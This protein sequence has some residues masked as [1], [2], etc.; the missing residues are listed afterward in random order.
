[1]HL[2]YRFR[3]TNKIVSFVRPLY[4]IINCLINFCS[5]YLIH[6]PLRISI[7]N[8]LVENFELCAANIFFYIDESVKRNN[9]ARKIGVSPKG[10]LAT[11]LRNFTVESI[12]IYISRSILLNFFSLSS[13]PTNRDPHLSLARSKPTEIGEK[14]KRDI[15][16]SKQDVQQWIKARERKREKEATPSKKKKCIIRVNVRRDTFSR[17]D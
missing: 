1:M 14:L 5:C 3:G 4:I 8:P 7:W 17:F 12:Y 6:S 15:E 11:P 16:E 13:F 9:A 2:R 10:W